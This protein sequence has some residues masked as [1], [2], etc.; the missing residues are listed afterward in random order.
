M[1]AGY[2][3]AINMICSLVKNGFFQ[4]NDLLT[5]GALQ[6]IEDEHNQRLSKRIIGKIYDKYE[7]ELNLLAYIDCLNISLDFLKEIFGAVELKY[8]CLY[9]I[10][11]QDNTYT[12]R[13][14]QVVLDAIKSI[15]KLPDVKFIADRL[16]G[17]L[18]KKNRQKDISFFTLFRHNNSFISKVYQDK[19]TSEEQKKVIL[20]SRLQAENT[21][22]NQ[23]KYISLINALSLQPAKSLY[24]CLL[25]VDRNEIELSATNRGHINEKARDMITGLCDVLKIATNEDIKFE[26]LHH[27]GKLYV[28]LKNGENAELYF[29]R[30]LDIRPKAYATMLQ[31]AKIASSAK[32]SDILKAKGYVSG[33]MEASGKEGNVPLT[34]ILACYSDFL[35]KKPYADLADKYIENDFDNFSKFILTSLLTFNNQ[36]IPTLASFAYS[37]VY[38]RPEFMRRAIELLQDLPASSPDKRYIEACAY[39]KAIEYRLEDDKSTDE[40][41][42]IFASAKHYFELLKLEE[43]EERQNKD[44]KRK[45]YQELLMDAGE[46]ND[47]LSF[48]EYFEEKDSEFYYQNLAKIYQNLHDFDKAICNIDKAISKASDKDYGTSFIWNKA[49]IMHDMGDIECL[50]VLQEAIS[51]RKGDKAKNEWMKMKKIWEIE[52]KKENSVIKE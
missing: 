8:L 21:F 18:D 50:N 20:Y 35:S 30:A 47:A 22:D 37:F 41:K 3:L 46:W 24:D 6:K 5:D 48:S 12:F 10:L 16:S 42:A 38:K 45:R 34:I 28:K 33:I 7:T 27:I 36:A 49:C 25:L 51:M 52:F 4:I 9:S 15:S 44:Y 43:K 1:V 2:P 31:L 32:P 19:E 14:H 13:I 26:L 11:Q 23:S 40:A 17:Y 39:L 29:E